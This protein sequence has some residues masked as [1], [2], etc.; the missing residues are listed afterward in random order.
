MR[1]RFSVFSVSVFSVFSFSF[2]LFLFLFAFCCCCCRFSKSECDRRPSVLHE[3]RTTNTTF[4]RACP[5]RDAAAGPRASETIPSKRH[6]S[7]DVPLGLL[8]LLTRTVGRTT[9]TTTTAGF[10][11]PPTPPSPLG[12]GWHVPS[13]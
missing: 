11:Q 13:A 4:E 8:A 7:G 12:R 9:T 2:S 1:R 5:G 6:R 3:R 10:A